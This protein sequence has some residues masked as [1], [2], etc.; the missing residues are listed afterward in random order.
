MKEG[1]SNRI[2]FSRIELEVG[3]VIEASV[4]VVAFQ[5]ELIRRMDLLAASRPRLDGGNLAEIRE[6]ALAA[7]QVM[8]PMARQLR[9]IVTGE[10]AA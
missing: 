4:E 6:H 10:E 7:L 1:M 2:P 5:D 9:S 3:R 8:D